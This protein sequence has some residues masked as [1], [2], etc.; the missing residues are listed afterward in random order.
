[1]F[2]MHPQVA[3]LNNLPKMVQRTEEWYLSRKMRITASEIASVLGVNPYKS[4]AEFWREK[5][6]VIRNEPE[7]V[8]TSTFTTE[9]GVKYEPVV[10]N[11]IR[12]RFHT[13]S[14]TLFEYGLI[15]HPNISF[16]GASP[17]GILFNGTMIEIKCT[18]SREIKNYEIVPYYYSQVQTQMECCQ[19]DKC[20]FIECKFI[21][22][23]SFNSFLLDSSKES[24]FVSCENKKKGVI[25]YDGSKYNY[26][27]PKK[28]DNEKKD[29]LMW[30]DSVSENISTFKIFY[31]KCDVMSN[32]II[33]KNKEY[34]DNMINETR[35]FWESLK[36]NKDIESEKI[37]CPYQGNNPNRFMFE[38]FVTDFNVIVTYD[39]KK[40]LTEYS[41][42]EDSVVE[43]KSTNEKKFGFRIK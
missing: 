42:Q 32:K 26:Y 7:K 13:D 36:K 14:E 28:S 37:M 18:V 6:A 8:K 22:Y 2:I 19:L 4:T 9:W 10:Q 1:M 21:E 39:K 16:L 20:E 27:E 35:I 30:I 15:T 17:D 25:L 3:R 43:S 34:V 23:S 5:L 11:M 38:N 24:I 31:W 41:N 40:E 29:I 12:A 33:S